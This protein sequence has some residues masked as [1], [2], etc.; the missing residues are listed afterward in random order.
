MLLKDV[1]NK[2]AGQVFSPLHYTNS[3]NSKRSFG[4]DGFWLKYLLFCIPWLKTQQP[5]LLY[6]PALL[7]KVGTDCP[8]DSFTLDL[9]FWHFFMP[10]NGER[11]SSWWR[12]GILC[13][14]LLG[15]ILTFIKQTVF[16]NWAIF[17]LQW[18]QVRLGV[19]L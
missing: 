1:K 10:T 6:W 19:V 18:P 14:W 5:I 7:S 9:T 15:L 17:H 4:Y 12:V 16:K 8:Y 2:R 13:K 11:P 3:Q